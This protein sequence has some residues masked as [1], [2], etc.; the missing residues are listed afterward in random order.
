M[1]VGVRSLGGRVV[2][3]VGR[4][5]MGCTI[6]GCTSLAVVAVSCSAR[7]VLNSA[8]LACRASWPCWILVCTCWGGWVRVG[9]AE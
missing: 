6:M 5:I 4:K 1:G 8:P 9:A 2:R 7:D 3:G